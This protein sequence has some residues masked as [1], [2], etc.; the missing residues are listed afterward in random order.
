[1][2]RR[3]HVAEDLAQVP[4]FEGLTAK[5]LSIVARL[6]TEV[7]VPA[8]RTTIEAIRGWQF[9]PKSTIVDVAA[10]GCSAGF[11]VGGVVAGGVAVF[12]GTSLSP[13]GTVPVAE[14][15]GWRCRPKEPYPSAASRSSCRSPP[16]GRPG[17]G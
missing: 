2:F 14:A 13:G 17:T 8:G 3:S 9:A 11:S 15:P 7:E 5:E 4:L 16:R 12:A 10:G 6:S 1:M